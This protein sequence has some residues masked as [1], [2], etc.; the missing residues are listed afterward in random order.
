MAPADFAGLIIDGFKHTFAPNAVIRARPPVDSI[1]WFGKVDRVAGMGVDNK[2]SVFRVEASGPIIG[3]AAFV[4]S[5]QAPV[6]SWLLGGIRNRTTLGVDSQRPVHRTERR[7][8]KV[9]S[10]GTID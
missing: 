1:S 5:N 6:G 4:G 9:L 10:I 2:Q 3:K 8:Q 7:S